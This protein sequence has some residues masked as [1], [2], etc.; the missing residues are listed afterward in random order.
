MLLHRTFLN[1]AHVQ[2]IQNMFYDIVVHN[3][4]ISIDSLICYN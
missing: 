4:Q 2:N 3:N 1:I